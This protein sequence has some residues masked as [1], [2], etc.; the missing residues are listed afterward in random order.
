MQNILIAFGLALLFI[1][2]VLVLFGEMLNLFSMI[3]IILPLVLLQK[4]L[5]LIID[6][7]I[8]R[9]HAYGMEEKKLKRPE[10]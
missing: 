2:P 6:Y 8:R 3:G 7:V 1:Y 10:L 5:I 4:K 9:I